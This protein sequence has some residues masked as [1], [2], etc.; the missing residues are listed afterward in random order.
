MGHGHALE[1]DV[2]EVQ[3]RLVPE[4]VFREF[5][6]AVE[7][8]YAVRQAVDTLLETW[9]KLQSATRR[10]DP[11]ESARYADEIEDQVAI[12]EI[13][14]K[15]SYAD[16]V[17]REVRVPEFSAEEAWGIIKPLIKAPS[18]RGRESLRRS[19]DNDLRYM[20]V[21]TPNGDRYRRRADT[22][23][24]R[25]RLSADELGRNI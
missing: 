18:D 20:R 17:A 11:G 24:Q 4:S 21:K 7:D 25:P 10:L 14:K 2:S 13:S 15:V 22:L 9:A 1:S 23:V 5:G 3:Y 16:V 12:Y 8:L 6:A 19:L